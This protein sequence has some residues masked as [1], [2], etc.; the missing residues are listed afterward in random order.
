MALV[1]AFQYQGRGVLMS[2]SDQWI[3]RSEAVGKAQARYL[4]ILLVTMIF[5]AALQ[6]RV[7][8]KAD[9]TSLTVPI[10]DLEISAAVVLGF[11]PALISFLVLAVLGTMRAYRTAR[12]HLGL[13][14]SADWS[15]EE[16]DTA[17]NAIDL[18]FYT[19]RH[20]PKVVVTVIHFVYVGFLLVALLEAAWIA[21]SLVDACERARWLFLALGAA[22]WIPA[23]ILL[24]SVIRRRV[25]DVP[26]LWKTK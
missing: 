12:Q 20:S 9:V 11:G 23:V 24:L 15:G 22:L 6:E 21:K 8:A 25:R 13:R 16:F 26:T 19:T 14:S 2:Q 10:V 17:P 3:S 7:S 18:A 1:A 4:W 5:Y